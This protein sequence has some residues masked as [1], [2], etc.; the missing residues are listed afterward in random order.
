MVAFEDESL[1]VTVWT[2]VYV[3]APGLKVGV[4]AAGKL[5]VYAADARL[6][7]T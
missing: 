1:M 7:W 4:A 2:E 3:P 5:M 6:L